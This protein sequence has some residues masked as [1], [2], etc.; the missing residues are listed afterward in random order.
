MRI[1][2]WNCHHGECRDRAARVSRFDP[3][4]VILQEC[5]SPSLAPDE[6]CLWFG[7]NPRKGVGIVS[8][9]A[10]RLEPGPAAPPDL[11]STYAVRV[12]ATLNIFAS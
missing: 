4:L 9:S 2:T 11:D 1:V 10:W 5:A 12:V 3:D 7:S 6:H 8:N